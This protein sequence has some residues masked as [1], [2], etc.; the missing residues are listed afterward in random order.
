MHYQ[1]VVTFVPLKF[2]AFKASHPNPNQRAYGVW[3]SEIMLQ[4]TQVATVIDYYNR[5]M[6]VS[7]TRSKISSLKYYRVERAFTFIGKILRYSDGKQL[8]FGHHS[9]DQGTKG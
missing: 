1:S 3:V 2:F 5:W 6:M 7:R 8:K 9:Q 4:Q